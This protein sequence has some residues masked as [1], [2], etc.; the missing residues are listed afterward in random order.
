M[1]HSQS[2]A[3]T[4]PRPIIRFRPLRVLPWIVLALCLVFVSSVLA[5]DIFSIVYANPSGVNVLTGGKV[6]VDISNAS[7]GYIMARH[8]GS[9][10]RLK[11]RVTYGQY[12]Y[13]Y[14]MNNQGE[15][16]TFPLQFGSGEYLI[17]VFENT[18]DSQYAL[19][20]NQ[21]FSVSMENPNDAFLCPNQY[22]WYT[23]TTQAIT[24]SFEL[25]AD[26]TT[27]LERAQILYEYVGNTI[28]YDYIKALMASTGELAGYLPDVDTTLDTQMG[29][30]F[31]YASL[32]ACM[33]RVQGIP[34]KL[35]IGDLLTQNQYHAW[36]ESYIDGKWVLMDPTFKS[37]DYSTTDYAMERFY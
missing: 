21:N 23:P 5:Y 4:R 11:A 13:Q 3:A 26:A 16:E 2:L 20:F 35:V 33:M 24:K 19:V 30:C 17:E 1:D 32:L 25:C 8:T 7:R 36:N 15:Y 28:M 37:S 10:K 27:D 9:E 34:T 12:V 29:I 22:V 31:D 18:R 14:D 6:T